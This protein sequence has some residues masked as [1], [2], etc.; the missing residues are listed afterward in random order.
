MRV[1]VAMSGGVD[2]SV[3][4]AMMAQEGHQVIGLMLRLWSEEGCKD[5]ACCTPEAVEQA[6]S[7]AERLGFPFYVLD[8]R[9][10]FKET[11]VDPFTATYLDAATPNP[12]LLCNQKV[13]FGALMDEALKLGAEKLVTGHYVRLSQADSGRYELR[14]GLDESK[15]Q[16][17]VLY[18]LDQDQLS[19]CLF[20]LGGMEKEAVRALAKEFRLEVASKPDSQDLCF[21]GSG[22]YRGFLDRAVGA[23]IQP[24]DFVDLEGK[25]L[26]RHQGLTH[27]TVGQRRGLGLSLPAPLYVVALDAANNRVI[28]GPKEARQRSEL[29]VEDLRF[30]QPLMDYL[31]RPLGARIRYNM[32]TTPVKVEPMAQGRIQLSFDPP[33]LDATPGQGAVLYDGDLVLG[34]GTIA[35]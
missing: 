6:R 32:N 17:Y 29:V 4:A 18:R 19:K 21:V 11:V 27:Y 34:G 33:V 7:V 9:D 2:S 1:V 3:A 10:F 20:P 26:G 22:G 24:G 15:D 23:E 12:C 31:S 16:S 35:K 25:V 13:R 28:L 14:R 30:Q 8:Y 5:N